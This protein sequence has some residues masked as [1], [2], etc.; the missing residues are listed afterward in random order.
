M[1]TH[2]LYIALLAS[3]AAAQATGAS[4]DANLSR[5]AAAPAKHHH[6]SLKSVKGKPAANAPVPSSAAPASTKK[7]AEMWGRTP[8]VKRSLLGSDGSDDSD[9]SIY[10]IVNILS[11]VDDDSDKSN[12]DNGS[13]LGLAKRS[14]IDLNQPA[15]NVL[16]SSQQS[17]TTVVGNNNDVSANQNQDSTNVNSNNNDSDDNDS[18]SGS[19]STGSARG[20]SGGQRKIVKT[21]RPATQRAVKQRKEAS[22]QK[23][24]KASPTHHTASHRAAVY[25]ATCTGTTRTVHHTA[26][27]TA[28]QTVTQ[29]VTRNVYAAGPTSKP[30]PTHTSNGLLDLDVSAAVGKVVTAVASLNVGDAVNAVASIAAL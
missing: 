19:C 20:R 29:T 23:V 5:R 11:D 7:G 30:T 2:V 1:L 6:K 18:G 15:V 17:Q 27:H 10:N 13:L 9:S 14:L 4:P 26:T 21:V 24:A 25:K 28:T 16:G 12:S 8:G 3:A 22:R